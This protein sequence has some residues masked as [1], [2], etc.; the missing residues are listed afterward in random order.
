MPLEVEEVEEEVELE[1]LELW[2]LESGQ[3]VTEGLDSGKVE[4]LGKLELG[5]PVSR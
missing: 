2:R 3:P 5:K 4:S 1:E